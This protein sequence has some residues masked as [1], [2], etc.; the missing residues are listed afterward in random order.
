MLVF[1]SC[2]DPQTPSSIW[3]SVDPKQ[4]LNL[5]LASTFD[6]G[7]QTDT[8]DP[9]EGTLVHPFQRRA[10]STVLEE[11][12]PKRMAVSSRRTHAL[13]KPGLSAIRGLVSSGQMNEPVLYGYSKHYKSICCWG[14]NDP[15]QHCGGRGCVTTKH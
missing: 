12:D 2:I 3:G 6:E 4:Y 8:L 7:S 10:N 13:Q 11:M 9:I 5:Q 1:T 14:A 15:K